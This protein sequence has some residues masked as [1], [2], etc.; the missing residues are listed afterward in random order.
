[1]TNKGK[2]AGAHRS[3]RDG[4]KC[5][6]LGLDRKASAT[7]RPPRGA[8][9]ITLRALQ[10]CSSAAQ[11]GSRG[12]DQR[13]LARLGFVSLRFVI[14]RYNREGIQFDTE[15]EIGIVDHQGSGAQQFKVNL[16]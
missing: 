7:L 9:T 15:A 8:S 3:A 16:M 2:R 12:Q 10:G 4:R 14:I 5:G 6:F 1:M 13:K 11:L